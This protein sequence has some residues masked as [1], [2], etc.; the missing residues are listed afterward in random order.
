M[1]T[2]AKPGR[3]VGLHPGETLTV[4][5]LSFPVPLEIPTDSTTTRRLRGFVQ[6]NSGKILF[7][8]GGRADDETDLFVDSGKEIE[9]LAK[10]KRRLKVPDQEFTKE[11]ARVLEQGGTQS[12]IA[13]E[14]AGAL[15][16]IINKVGKS[17]P[18]RRA[19]SK[20]SPR[21]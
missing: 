15:V 7:L 19:R 1:R 8:L 14:A 16:K 11:I 9:S 2:E 18:P 5:A 17:L 20:S 4:V 12:V 13:Q 6:R 10:R 21:P 3:E